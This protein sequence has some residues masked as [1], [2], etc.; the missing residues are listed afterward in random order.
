MKQYILI[1]GSGQYNAEDSIIPINGNN[2]FIIIKR[3]SN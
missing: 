3:M 2:I 1:T